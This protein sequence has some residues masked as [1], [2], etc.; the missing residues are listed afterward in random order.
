MS[1]KCFVFDFDCTIT[2]THWFYFVHDFD[3]YK[4]LYNVPSCLGKLSKLVKENRKLTLYEKSI[5]IKYIM[6][7]Y[8]RINMLKSFLAILIRDGYS[9]FIASRG[10]VED[11][12]YLLKLSGLNVFRY[13]N[14]HSSEH[15]NIS[16]DKFL[17]NLYQR[18]YTKIRYVDD[19]N[20][21]HNKL[22]LENVDYFYYGSNVNLQK[23]NLGL[24]S[25]MLNTILK[26]DNIFY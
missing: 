15:K 14:A 22:N 12:L 8:E 16:K 4:T 7:G 19:N 6:G 10:Y 3:K 2:F 9:L 11:I 1:K 21:E 5:L 25:N 17:F 20:E 23:E 18:G 26:H 13:I 24:T